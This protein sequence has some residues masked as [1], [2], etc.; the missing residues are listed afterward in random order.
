MK[1]KRIFWLI[2]AA[3]SAAGLMTV[4]N[5]LW[6]SLFS[7]FLSFPFYPVS[8]LLGKLSAP[9]GF[10][11][12]LAVMLMFAFCMLPL[13]FPICSAAVRKSGGSC[14]ACIA[15][16]VLLYAGMMQLT[17]KD[18]GDFKS[19]F[20]SVIGAMLWSG[21]V[22]LFVIIAIG[23]FKR[24]DTAKLLRYGMV[25]LYCL[26]FWA[27]GSMTFSLGT[28]VVSLFSV[29]ERIGSSSYHLVAAI[30]R[31][32][33]DVF[34]LLA[35]VSVGDLLSKYA[36]G[37]TDAI[38]PAARRTSARATVALLIAVTVC[39]LRNVITVAC[40]SVISDVD[41]SVN[42]PV[43]ETA[44]LLGVLLVCR[45]IERNCELQ[46]DSDMIV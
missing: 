16:T 17:T 43:A 14:A 36:C 22:G 45:L 46:N 32:V 25:S 13:L 3:A 5:V 40:S 35:I 41:V 37:E 2:A 39:I 12:G 24:A 23:A 10:C 34:L 15:L 18:F 8:I 30:L 9:G 26:V 31:C 29:S 6:P 7:S 28:Y 21:I 1:R 4:C 33:P 38:V 27:A 11:N 42:I 20:P 44:L 19:V